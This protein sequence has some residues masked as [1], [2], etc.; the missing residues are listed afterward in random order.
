MGSTQIR[1]LAE[2]DLGS[3]PLLMSDGAAIEPLYQVPAPVEAGSIPEGSTAYS[4]NC[5]CG[6]VGYTVVSPDKISTVTDCNCSICSRVSHTF[7]NLSACVD[8][9]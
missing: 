3:L 8:R 2:V 1:A 6:G 4:G 5:H 7:R 9:M